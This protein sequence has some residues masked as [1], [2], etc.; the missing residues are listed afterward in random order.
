MLP[1]PIIVQVGTAFIPGGFIRHDAGNTGTCPADDCPYPAGSQCARY[2]CPGRALSRNASRVNTHG[3]LNA[4]S[5][6][7]AAKGIAKRI[8]Q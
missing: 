6:P 7:V 4:A 1:I 5:S 8:S 2:P 3:P